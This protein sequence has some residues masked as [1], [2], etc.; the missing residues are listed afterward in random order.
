MRRGSSYESP[1]VIYHWYCH[2]YRVKVWPY[3]Y[4]RLPRKSGIGV[5]YK[6]I[7]P[8]QDQNRRQREKAR[9]PKTP[10]LCLVRPGPR[11][12]RPLPNAPKEPGLMRGV[13]MLGLDDQQIKLGPGLDDRCQAQAGDRRLDDLPDRKAEEPLEM[14]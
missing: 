6:N 1:K 7:P 8:S 13:F 12:A 10:A 9:N 5:R 4:L 2:W 3:S 14:H 11:S